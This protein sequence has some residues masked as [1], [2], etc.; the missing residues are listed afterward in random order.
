M[1]GDVNVSDNSKMIRRSNSF[2]N[3]NFKQG[4]YS[5]VVVAFVVAIV[6]LLNLFVGQ[7]GL[8]VDLTK[9]NI[10]TLTE[11]TEEYAESITDDITIYYVVKEGEE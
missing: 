11:E 3:R 10:Y 7:M 8:S 6:I 9:E 1:K 5:S 2:S 4:M